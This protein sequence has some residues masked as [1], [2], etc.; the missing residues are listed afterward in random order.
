MAI[1]TYDLDDF[2]PHRGPMRLVDRLG[3]VGDDRAEVFAQVREDWPLV[4]D[5]RTDPVVLIEVVAQAAAA[6][7]GYRKRHEERLGGRGWLV[8]IRR[9]E[10]TDQSLTV[11]TEL[12]VEVRV[13]YQLKEYAVFQGTVTCAGREL[14]QV[15]VQT[16]KPDDSFWEEPSHHGD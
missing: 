10:L 2:I 9:T 11:G 3:E 14:A 5:G 12:R 7:A 15:E 16:F 1:E 8:G 6:L 4:A 13:D